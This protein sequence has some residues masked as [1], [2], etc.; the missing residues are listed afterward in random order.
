MEM[1]NTSIITLGETFLFTLAPSAKLYPW[2]G[3]FDVESEDAQNSENVTS[4]GTNLFVQ[5]GGDF[6]NIGA[7]GSG[8]GLHLDEMLSKGETSH[9][10]TFGNDPL[11]GDLWLHNKSM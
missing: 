6:L 10:K 9:C 7:G 4:Y 1:V 2:V 8:I 5:S 3:R 11:T